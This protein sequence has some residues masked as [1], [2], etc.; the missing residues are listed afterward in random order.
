MSVNYYYNNKEL[1]LTSDKFYIQLMV[2]FRN[3]IRNEGD[4]KIDIH[5]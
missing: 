3:K 4:I 1:F 5:C 2:F